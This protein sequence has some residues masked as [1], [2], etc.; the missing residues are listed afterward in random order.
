MKFQ[1]IKIEEIEEVVP[2]FLNEG[3][4]ELDNEFLQELKEVINKREL[5]HFH[6]FKELD[7]WLDESEY[8]A[9]LFKE[10]DG[11]S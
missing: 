9:Q 4:E 3:K 7:D 8:W 2:S 1:P 10:I 11:E 6:E 5:D